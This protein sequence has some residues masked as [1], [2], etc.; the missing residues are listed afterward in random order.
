[1]NYLHV[2][3]TELT[4]RRHLRPNQVAL[5]NLQIPALVN[6]AVLQARS[7]ATQL[8]KEN[9]TFVLFGLSL[10]LGVVI[11][12]LVVCI[13]QGVRQNDKYKKLLRGNSTTSSSYPV[14]L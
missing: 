7:H 14:N 5:W 10:F 12:G 8:F 2:E 4:M 3:E 11:L 1:M 13:T 6:Q 9:L